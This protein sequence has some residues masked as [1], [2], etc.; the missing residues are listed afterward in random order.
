MDD[1][2]VKIIKSARKLFLENG[3]NKTGVQEIIEDTKLSK[4]TFYHY[5]KSK[6]N[7]GLAVA[8]YNGKIKEE[9]FKLAMEEK[10]WPDFVDKIVDGL[11][12][13][14][15]DKLKGC[16][17]AVAGMEMAFTEEK[18]GE[19]NYE[20]ILTMEDCFYNFLLDLSGESDV[21]QEI[22]KKAI[23]IYQGA[24]LMYRLSKDKAYIEDLRIY[25]KDLG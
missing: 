7:L 12:K 19:K 9:D 18:I 4:G 2:K 10:S 21:S 23:L 14:K 15:S 11:I 25:L 17:F 6:L 24:L 8:D 13:S 20:A 1:N 3:Y 5:F 16:P 22:S